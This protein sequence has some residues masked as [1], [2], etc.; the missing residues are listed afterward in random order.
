MTTDENRVRADD[1]VADRIPLL[2]VGASRR[3]VLASTAGVGA[4]A[5]AGVPYAAVASEHEGENGNGE[6]D[7]ENGGDGGGEVDAPEGFEVEVLAPHAS[8]VGDV[9]AAFSVWYDDGETELGLVKD[10]STVL[11]A[12]VTIAPNGTSGW[13][14]HPGPVLVSVVEGTIDITIDEDCRTRTFGTGEAYLDTGTHAE[15]A[16][17]PSE[18]DPAVLYAVFLG[19]PDGESPTNWVE[20]RDC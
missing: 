7:G 11:V 8:F 6:D 19:V 4:V 16:T 9:A 20:P 18:T 17:N 5:L 2:P 1:S 12:R 14:V 15:V 13:H 10:A 3:R